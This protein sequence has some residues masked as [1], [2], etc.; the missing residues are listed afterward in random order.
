MNVSANSGTGLEAV[1]VKGYTRTKRNGSSHKV[2]SH[3]RAPRG[4]GELPRRELVQDFKARATAAV[5]AAFSSY[6]LPIPVFRITNVK[7]RRTKTG[8]RC[9]GIVTISAPEGD[10]E[11]RFRI[12]DSLE[13]PGSV[14]DYFSR[15]SKIDD[16]SG[17][18]SRRNPPGKGS[19]AGSCMLKNSPAALVRERRGT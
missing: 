7:P 12:D 6:S 3:L 1:P 4:K 18:T 14:L 17:R 11:L 15:S 13:I 9:Q 5:V 10:A 2:R 16:G 19:P 8:I